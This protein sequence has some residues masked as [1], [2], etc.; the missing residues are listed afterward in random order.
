MQEKVI[1][2]NG[3]G[4]IELQSPSAILA[5]LGTPLLD[6]KADH[7]PPPRLEPTP[8]TDGV[9]FEPTRVLTHTISNRAP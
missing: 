2:P 8:S 1:L 7:T 9:G 5:R 6:R 4:G 3:W